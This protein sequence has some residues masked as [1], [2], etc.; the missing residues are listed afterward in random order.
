MN[1]CDVELQPCLDR[2]GGIVMRLYPDC[3]IQRYDDCLIVKKN[4]VSKLNLN[5]VLGDLSCDVVTVSTMGVIMYSIAKAMFKGKWIQEAS[6]RIYEE[7]YSDKPFETDTARFK[8]KYGSYYASSS[9]ARAGYWG[10]FLFACFF[11]FA[12]VVGLV[13]DTVKNRTPES[14]SMLVWCLVSGTFALL[15][16]YLWRRKKRV[17]YEEC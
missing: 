10:G 4:W 7:Y 15:F 3:K 2:I 17:I 6:C 14:S 9:K 8:A 5:F 1:D 12:G 16:W 11:L 13:G